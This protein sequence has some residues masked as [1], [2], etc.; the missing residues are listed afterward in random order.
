MKELKTL[1]Q[2]QF[3]SRNKEE[4][5]LLEFLTRCKTDSTCYATAAERML[6]AIGPAKIVNTTE[7]PR[8]SRIFSNRKIKIYQTFADF[9]G[10]EDTIENIVSHFKHAAQNLEESKQ[11]LYLLGPVG[12]G[13]S[14]LAERLKKLMEKEPIYVLKAGNEISPIY[15]SP[16]GLFDKATH[17]TML[18]KDY[19]I[20]ERYLRTIN[21]PWAQKRLNEF[22]G[23]LTK[24]TV[25]K[26]FPS[27]IN[28][29][30]ISK[31]EPGDENNQDISTL[32]GS[33]NINKL[34]RLGEDDPDA[35]GYTGALNI[36][37][38]GIMEFVEMFKA[39]IKMLNPLLT[40]TQ[41]S[42]YNGTRR[43]GAIPFQGII[44]AHCF[45]EDTELLTE[46]GWKYHHQIDN[47]TKLATF[48]KSTNTM[49]FHA[50]TKEFKQ[51]YT[52]RMI[53]FD[54]DSM[55][56]LVTPNHKMIYKTQ[57]TSNW[58]VCDAGEY[59]ATGKI[60]PVSAVVH[61]Q[62]YDILD[63]ELRLMVWVAAD[64]SLQGNKIRWHLAKE[65]KIE[66]LTS[67]LD[68]MNIPYMQRVDI[69]TGNHNI[70]ID[71]TINISK[72]LPEYF[73]SLSARQAS[74]VITEYSHT[75]GTRT[76]SKGNTSFEND[77]DDTTHLQLSSNNIDNINLL[78]YLCV[79]SGNKTNL[80]SHQKDKY[81]PQYFLSV[82]L[83]ITQTR[84]DYA[85]NET[86]YDGLV[87][88]Y[89]TPNNTLVARRNGKVIIT[90]NSNESEWETFKNNRNNEAFLDR[91]NLINVPYCLRTDEEVQ[92]YEKL[93][94]N[95]EL[96]DAPIAPKTLEMLAQFSILTRLID[97]EN[98]D[99]L[100]KLL[101]YNG[102]YIKEIMPK[103][104]SQKEYKDLAGVREGM[105]GTSTR[106]AYKILSKVFN[107]DS[108]EVSANPIHLMY[109]LENQIKQEC[110]SSDKE[111]EYV[112]F[113]HTLLKAKYAEFVEEEL[114][115][116]YLESYSDYG[117]NLFDNYVKYAD[118][119][120]QD[121]EYRDPDTGAM[122]N[123]EALNKELEKMEKPA[124]IS[125]PKDFRHEIVNFV[126]RAK[127][128][129][130]GIMPVWTSYEKLRR[131]IEKRMFSN[132]D[133]LLP[134]ISFGT[135]KSS[136]EEDK[137]HKFVDRMIARGYTKRQIQL[138]VSWYTQY[139]KSN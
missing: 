43:F 131:V 120:T 114:Q 79:I 73:Y 7:N 29:I 47:T 125:N 56:H 95:S 94:Q 46:N 84:T 34:Q 44:L 106:F 10:M 17:G 25:V 70:S 137:H 16:L 123:R 107:F 65:R 87:F 1:F 26:M 4:M 76:D 19:G 96:S 127:A 88:C 128:D 5:S 53:H 90:H 132:T 133:E 42:N 103:A 36:A 110:F 100:A 22:E 74:V 78:Q 122:M 119:W 24:F 105:E 60:I 33:V 124:M 8:L 98:S 41:E 66:R 50:P 54:S 28:Q 20:A 14:S 9:F 129:K 121:Q 116:A 55:D 72:N 111:S 11:I 85:M 52:G 39:P 45:S 35:Y 126:L 99:I 81:S 13:K 86:T 113:I 112:A 21:S 37:T 135:K 91:V 92:I 27:I 109:I 117:Q 30:A 48:N 51:Q 63:N 3:N 82:R 69:V 18:K 89:E 118:F 38:Q 57:Y 101:V 83:G 31:A 61:R 104:K 102:D 49:E 68:T 15:E 97:P 75:D 93:I 58:K 59:G 6:K 80:C 138:I 71:N 23:D 77:D 62:D 115:K 108:E 40:A 136:D 139:N 2:D 130:G 12:G 64:G 134:I 67:L 32:V